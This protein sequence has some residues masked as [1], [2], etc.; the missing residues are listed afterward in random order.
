MVRCGREPG[1]SAI[2]EL[3]SSSIQEALRIYFQPIKNED[4]RLDFYTT[5]KREATEYDTEYMKKYNEDLNTNLIFVWLHSLLSRPRHLPRP[6]AGLFSA[7][8]SAFVIN[9][10]SK[11]EPDPSERSEVYLR[12]ILLSLN[13]SIAPDEHPTALLL[14]RRGVVL[15]H[16]L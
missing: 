4:P 12:A 3:T 8:S 11:L 15:P 5:Y 9:A 7:V 6:Q 13:R 14:P 1:P 16:K 2:P 10:Q